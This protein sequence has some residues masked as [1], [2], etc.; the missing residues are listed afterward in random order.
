MINQKM[1]K[2]KKGYNSQEQDVVDNSFQHIEV[3][4]VAVVAAVAVAVVEQVVA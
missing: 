2:K 4:P 3:V 1:I